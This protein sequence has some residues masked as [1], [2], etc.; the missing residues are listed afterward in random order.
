MIK[1]ISRAYTDHTQLIRLAD[2]AIISSNG[3]NKIEVTR[4]IDQTYIPDYPK[5]SV[6]G[7]LTIIHQSQRIWPLGFEDITKDEQKRIV[8][9]KITE[10]MSKVYNPYTMHMHY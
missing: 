7:T 4:I 10:V 1:V 3:S 2:S 5:T 8:R 9:E 6:D